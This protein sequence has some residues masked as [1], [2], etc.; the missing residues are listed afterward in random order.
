M[1]IEMYRKKEKEGRIAQEDIFLMNQNMVWI[2]YTEK[3]L[4]CFG[5]NII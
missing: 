5:I 4:F 2:Y 1:K 3:E